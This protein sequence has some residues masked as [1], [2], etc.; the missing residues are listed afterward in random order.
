[1][2]QKLKRIDDL[3]N[4]KRELDYQEFQELLQLQREVACS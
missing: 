3:E 1:M 4:K 2:E